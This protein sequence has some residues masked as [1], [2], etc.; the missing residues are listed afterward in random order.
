[1]LEMSLFDYFHH[2]EHQ[3]SIVKFCQKD[4]GTVLYL[5]KG[6]GSILF[7][8]RLVIIIIIIASPYEFNSYYHIQISI[9]I[10]DCNNY[11]SEHKFFCYCYRYHY[12]Y[13]SAVIYVIIN[14]IVLM[15]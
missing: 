3:I 13:D 2:F 10:Y 12:Y 8:P 11:E 1:M 5:V 9:I 7:S 14:I 4:V 6:F 15:N